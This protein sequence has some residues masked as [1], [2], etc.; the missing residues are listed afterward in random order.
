MKQMLKKVLLLYVGLAMCIQCCGIQ[1]KE[2]VPRIE[3][4]KIVAV[5]DIMM[6]KEEIEGG[7]V[8]ETGT[9]SFDYMF[10]AVK[11]YIE[12]AD[13]AIGNLETPLAGRDRGYTGYPTFNAPEQLAQAL[14]NTGFDT[15]TTANNHSLDRHY[16]GVAHTL[17][18]LD[19]AGLKYTG[20]ART[21]EEQDQILI[22]DIKG[23]KI[24]F[25]AYTYGTNGINPDKGKDYCVNYLNKEKM[26]KDIELAKSQ[27]VDLICVSMHFGDE[28]Q[29]KQNKKQEE[30][31]QFLFDKGVDIVLGSHPHVLQ[32]M[33]LEED[34]FVI[35]SL[36]NFVSAQ[37]THYRDSSILLN[38][39]ITKNFETGETIIDSVEYVPI[40]TD[41]SRIKDKPHFRVL[42]VEEA[43][44]RYEN[45]TDGHISSQDYSKLKTSLSDTSSMYKRPQTQ[46]RSIQVGGKSDQY[47][48]FE[49]DGQMFVELR[50]L[51]EN[52]GAEIKW[53]P[54]AMQMMLLVDEKVATITLGSRYLFFEGQWVKL[55]KAIG[56]IDGKAFVP[57]REFVEL[58]GLQVDYDRMTQVVSI[59]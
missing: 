53:N 46:L 48:T 34:Q 43:L 37:R 28:Y 31:V 11:P 45:K 2:I 36:G 29:R 17:K 16:Q 38:L 22:Q 4:I 15:L 26:L 13:L 50:K 58:I 18:I 3:T 55:Q 19:E 21:K 6:H 12:K 8:A 23:I 27:G 51:S 30:W 25:M 47:L 41:L 59:H 1:A 54:E 44:K 49:S 9:Y 56:M 24:A 39:T 52:L 5:G 57:M 7:R 10:E 40:W 33:K 14:K 20:T 32:P 35:Y 42:P